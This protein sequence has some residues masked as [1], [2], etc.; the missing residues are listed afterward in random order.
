MYKGKS[1]DVTVSCRLSGGQ[2]LPSLQSTIKDADE[3]LYKAKKD[4]RN[5][6][7]YK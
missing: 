1:I 7:A 4:G 2:K 5:Q 3:Y 6:V